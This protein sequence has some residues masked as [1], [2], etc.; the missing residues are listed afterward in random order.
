[1]KTYKVTQKKLGRVFNDTISAQNIAQAKQI[2]VNKRGGIVIEVRE[3]KDI[4]D[5]NVIKNLLFTPKIKMLSYISTLRQLAVMTDAGISIHDS[6]NEVVNNTK[7][8]R[9]A[10]IFG[11]VRDDLDAGMNIS[12]SIVQFERDVGNVS[13]ALISLGEQTGRLAESLNHLVEILQDVYDNRQKF[14]KA[15]RYPVVVICAIIIA[16]ILLMVLVVPKFRDVFASFNAELP[17]PTRILLNIEWA[18]SNYG[19]AIGAGVLVAILI[20]ILVYH[21]NQGFKYSF[22]KYILK[23]YLIGNIIFFSTMS[24]FN[25]VFGELVRSGLPVIDA[26]NTSLLNVENSFLKERLEGVKISVSR[27]NSLSSSVAATELYENM[28]VQMIA[29]GE[30]SGSIDAMLARITAY[31]KDRFN[32]IL[33]NISAYIEPILLV[34][35]AGMVILMA[36]GIFMPMW[37][38]AKAVK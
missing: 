7:D 16:F 4:F 30:R 6:I 18:F 21:R 33:D 38:L 11:R 8:K 28:L 23:L 32:N 13:I 3:S 35:I 27:G 25:L 29:A 37:D 34:F 14:K 24:R 10:Q 9:V 22:D 17:L 5:P 19:F 2:A 12:E 31:Y 20:T 15:I 1:M 26:L 36:L